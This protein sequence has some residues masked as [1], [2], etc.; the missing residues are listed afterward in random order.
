MNKTRG[1]PDIYMRPATAFEQA[2][3]WM[4]VFLSGLINAAG[5]G[6]FSKK[7]LL[8]CDWRRAYCMSKHHMLENLRGRSEKSVE[9][10]LCHPSLFSFK[11][12]LII[13]VQ[14]YF[15]HNFVE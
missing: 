12:D 3:K 7:K 14:A 13:I 11:C 5:T 15:S 2:I 4:T 9:R 10:R 6:K 8:I 1:Q